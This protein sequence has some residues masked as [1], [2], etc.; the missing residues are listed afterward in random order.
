MVLASRGPAVSCAVV[1]ALFC[2][3]P[4]TALSFLETKTALLHQG[5]VNQ[6]SYA[7][8]LAEDQW[9]D[10]GNIRAAGAGKRVLGDAVQLLYMG[11]TI[12]KNLLVHTLVSTHHKAS[13]A[14]FA[15]RTSRT[16]SVAACVLRAAARLLCAEDRTSN[17]QAENASA[18]A[19][20][21]GITTI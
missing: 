9:L 16:A 17:T 13:V 19:A 1:Y 3:Y 5:V 7:F 14:L 12:T 15:L 18:P 20:H 21:Q 11:H 4:T 2:K 10:R 8:Y 6:V